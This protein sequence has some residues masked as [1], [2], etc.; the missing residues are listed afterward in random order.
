[1][2]AGRRLFRTKRNP[3]HVF[4]LPHETWA[5]PVSPDETW[6]SPVSPVDGC[7]DLGPGWRQEGA[8][9]SPSVEPTKP[10]L[11]L[12]PTHRRSRQAEKITQGFLRG[13]LLYGVILSPPSLSL[14]LPLLI[15]RAHC[16]TACRRR[17]SGGGRGIKI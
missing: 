6:A 13:G 16:R 7:C 15:S 10:G 1:M 8:C 14:A 12:C 3:C 5:S 2:N 11:R 9:H 17:E 4:S